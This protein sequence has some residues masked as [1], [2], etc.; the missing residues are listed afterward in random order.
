MPRPKKT[1]KTPAAILKSYAAGAS[2]AELK[3]KFGIRGKNQLASAV[4]DALISTGK[5]PPIA[6]GRAKKAVPAAFP[7][8]VNTRGTIVLPKE[9]VIDAFRCTI[10]QKFTARRR[11]KKLI[12]TATG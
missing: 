9:A 11:G 12:L 8:A 4:L 6:R 1:A 3:T 7:V 5:M 2:L 10:G